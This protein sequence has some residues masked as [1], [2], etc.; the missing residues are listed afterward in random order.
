LST[1]ETAARILK[2]L[3]DE[4]WRTLAGLERVSSKIGAG[5]IGRL[6]RTSHLPSERVAFAVDELTKKGLASRRGHGFALTREGVEA[7]ALKDY[8]R[9]DLLF[10]LGAIIAKGKESD[11]YEALTEEGDRYALKFYKIGRTSFTRVRRSRRVEGSAI[12]GWMSA[13][14]EAA[15]REYHALRKLEGLSP[16]FPKAITYSRNTVLLQQVSG[17]R[18]S[19]RPY[20]ED[21]R[22]AAADI[23]GSIRKAYTVGKLVNSDLSEYNVLTDGGRTWLIDWPQAVDVGHPNS[24]E[25]LAHDV[26]AVANFFDR[27]YGVVFDKEKVVAYVTGKASK[28]E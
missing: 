2:K 19:Q 13:N 12:K 5:D 6:S 8:V 27:A 26:S 9:K 22:G 28:L 3:K 23:F 1:V 25:L 11:V 15:R 10:A 7:M 24:G 4:E 16:S 14:Y 20:M 17:V 18:L 21:P